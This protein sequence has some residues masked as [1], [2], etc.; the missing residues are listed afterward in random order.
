MILNRTYKPVTNLTAHVEVFN[1]DSKSL[2]SEETNINLTPTDVKEI[3]P[4]TSLL[5]SAKGIVFVVLNLKNSSGKVISHNVYWLS[6]DGDYK[7]INELPATTIQT[8]ILKEES[9]KTERIWTIQIT[10]TSSKLAFFVRPQLMSGGEEMLP[11]FWSASYITLAPSESTNLTVSCP[12]AKLN[13]K[14]PSIVVSGWNVDR[15]ELSLR[16]R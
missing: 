6:S 1:Q 14:T 12:L 11:S 3:T 13:G 15:Q 7:S 16:T 8:R 5:G 4:L 9:S 10:N 2:F